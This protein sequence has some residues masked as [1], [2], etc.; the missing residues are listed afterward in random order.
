M[1]YEQYPRQH[2]LAPSQEKKTPE[3]YVKDVQSWQYKHLNDLSDIALVFLLLTMNIF[4]TFPVVSIVDLEQVNV[5]CD[6]TS[7][8]LNN[9]QSNK[10]AN[11]FERGF[12]L[13]EAKQKTNAD[14]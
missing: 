1:L 4:H 3:K 7:T 8:N 10:Y 6:S 5:Y 13:S 2:L 9:P 12:H 14:N 11:Y